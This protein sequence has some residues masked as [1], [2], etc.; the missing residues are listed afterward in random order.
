MQA[1]VS[2]AQQRSQNRMKPGR[3][4]WYWL[5]NLSAHTFFTPTYTIA[6]L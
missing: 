1:F 2:V 4:Y 3:Y 6:L 5:Y